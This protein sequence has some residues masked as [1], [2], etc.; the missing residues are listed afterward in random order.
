[1]GVGEVKAVNVGELGPLLQLVGD[2]FARADDCG[3]EAADRAMPG[4]VTDGPLA[5]LGVGLL[6]VGHSRLDGVAFDVADGLVQVVLGQVDS[7]PARHEH[8]GTFF[9]RV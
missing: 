9:A 7:H 1:Y 2:L 5:A 6:K 3:A 4:D 8:E